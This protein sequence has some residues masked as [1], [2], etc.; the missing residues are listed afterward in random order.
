MKLKEL[1]EK[2]ISEVVKDC[3]VVKISPFADDHGN[4]VKITIEYVPNE[5]EPVV[6]NKGVI[7][8]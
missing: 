4:I 2:G 1:L 5:I 7:M 6:P 3:N 8:K